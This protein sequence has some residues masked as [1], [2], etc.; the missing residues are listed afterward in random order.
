MHGEDFAILGYS[1]YLDWLKSEMQKKFEIKA[2]R[3]GPDD[4]DTK[5]FKLFNRIVGWT[6]QGLKIEGGQRHAEL[7]VK[8]LQLETTSK[9]VSTPYDTAY[10][11][12][13]EEEL[14][15]GEATHTVPTSL[16]ATS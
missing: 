4:D 14:P 15:L 7:I 16:E 1:K 12:D 9:S 11:A 10:K 8:D 3:I 13:D 5:S 6:P 2:T